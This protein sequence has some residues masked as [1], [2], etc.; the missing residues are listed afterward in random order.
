[1]DPLVKSEAPSGSGSLTTTVAGILALA[2]AAGTV[3]C[4]VYAVWWLVTYW[5]PW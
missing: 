5:A 4:L 3:F 1:M 2:A